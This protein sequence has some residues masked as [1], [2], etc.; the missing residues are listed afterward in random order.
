MST[1]T[2]P[3]ESVKATVLSLVE[4]SSGPTRAD[5]VVQLD[6]VGGG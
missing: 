6:V 2:P 5:K 4:I 3:S 1:E